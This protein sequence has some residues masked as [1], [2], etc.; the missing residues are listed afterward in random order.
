MHSEIAR[1]DDGRKYLRTSHISR[2]AR[3]L[4]STCTRSA[5]RP[6]ARVPLGPN[7]PGRRS[8]RIEDVRHNPQ[9]NLFVRR[10]GASVECPMPWSA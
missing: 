7:L 6:L 4:V 2:F 3:I 1:N 8:M 5:G 10:A 9:D